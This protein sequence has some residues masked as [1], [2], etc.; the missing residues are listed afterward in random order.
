MLRK[1]PAS[2]ENPNAWTNVSSLLIRKPLVQQL[3]NQN[4]TFIAVAPAFYVASGTDA[5]KHLPFY[6]IFY[7]DK[8]AQFLSPSH[9]AGVSGRRDLQQ[10]VLHN[11]D[12]DGI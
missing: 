9:F 11:L 3:T 5:F 12:R 6:I 4:A 8:N 2:P 1:L 7:H 10:L